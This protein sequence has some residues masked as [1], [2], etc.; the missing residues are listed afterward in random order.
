MDLSSIIWSVLCSAFALT[1]TAP[2]LALYYGGLVRRKNVLSVQIQCLYLMGLIGFC[3]GMWGYSLAFSEGNRWIG[4]LARVGMRGLH[5]Q[6]GVMSESVGAELG[7]FMFYGSVAVFSGTLICGA[8]AERLKFTALTMFM[9]LWMTLIFCPL[10]YWVW[11][12]GFLHGPNA[13]LGGRPTL[14]VPRSSI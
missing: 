10:S 12:N 14:P 9:V 8:F 11:G 7:Q 3:W 6:N 13:I 4:G 5:P 2:G 1:M